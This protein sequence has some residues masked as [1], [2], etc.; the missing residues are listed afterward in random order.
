[1][2]GLCRTI[3]TRDAGGTTHCH[4]IFGYCGSKALISE[5]YFRRAIGRR[6]AFGVS[7]YKA[8]A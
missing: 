5:G 6:Y 1:M 2:M 3:V 8:N 4:D 7:W